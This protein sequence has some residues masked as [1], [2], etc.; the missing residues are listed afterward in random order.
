M[1]NIPSLTRIAEIFQVHPDDFHDHKEYL[2][3]VFKSRFGRIRSFGDNPDI[4]W[5]G[6]ENNKQIC[7][8]SRQNQR[9]MC[10]EDAFINDY[11][12]V[13]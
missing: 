5:C 7:F 9:T 6:D 2:K 10:I 12:D 3:S 1:C 13:N 8:K 4:G 11:L